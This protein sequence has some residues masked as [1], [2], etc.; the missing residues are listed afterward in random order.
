MPSRSRSTGPGEKRRPRE[1]S[2]KVIVLGSA[3]LTTEETWL[4]AT[5]FRDSLKVNAPEFAVDSGPRRRIR[6]KR[7]GWLYGEEA[8]PNSR[9]CEAA[10]L[11]RAKEGGGVSPVPI[12]FK[13]ISLSPRRSSTSPTRASARSANDPAFVAELRKASVLIV[14]ARKRNALTDAADIVLPTAALSAR[15]ARS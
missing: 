7:D 5:L 14:H 13:E 4:L 10:G 2:S 1:I 6:N 3:F 11:K 9:G 8:A 12:T 15:K